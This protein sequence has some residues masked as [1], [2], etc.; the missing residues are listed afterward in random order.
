MMP[1]TIGRRLVTIACLAAASSGAQRAHAQGPADFRSSAP[2]ELAEPSGLHRFT[3]PFEAYRDARPDLSDLRVFNGAGQSVAFALSLGADRAST[4][5]TVALRQFAVFSS[6]ERA[7]G[8]LDVSVRTRADG[9]VISVQPRGTAAPAGERRPAAWLLDASAV[10]APLRALL[11]EWDAGPGTEVVHVNV[12]S[13]DD[14]RR[15]QPVARR[16]ALV[17]VEQGGQ[18]LAQPRVEFPAHEARYWRVSASDRASPFALHAVRAETSE[19]TPPLPRERRE[20]TGAGGRSPGEFVFDLD[21][22][23]PVDAVRVAFSEPNTV[24]R[25]E[26]LSRASEDDEWRHVTS[27]DFYRLTRD[28]AEVMSPTVEIPRRAHRHW[29]LRVDSRSG[30]TGSPT[31]EV[32]WR[33]ARV[34]F[35][36][37]GEPPFSVAFGS[38]EAPAARADLPLS[39]VIPDYTPADEYGLPVA[40]VGAVRTVAL[41]GD[42]WRRLVGDVNGRTVALWAVLFAGVAFLGFM[43]WKLSRQLPGD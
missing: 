4:I 29:L 19:G 12:E 28:G 33:P 39:S 35:V 11:V 15:W 20:Y 3:L 9:T 17:R 34:V 36:A 22:H 32:S 25:I 40:R 7:P 27:G 38:P 6:A 42:N 5:D 31:L 14:L 18:L 30:L 37:G 24:A 8:D 21:A 16:A 10:H 41:S 2:L 13:S 23:L 26:I 43:A 1:G